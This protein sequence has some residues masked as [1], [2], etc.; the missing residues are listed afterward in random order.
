MPDS[1][2]LSA[3]EKRINADTAFHGF[4]KIDTKISAC[5]V[6]KCRLLQFAAP[7][8]FHEVHKMH[9]GEERDD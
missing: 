8:H 5:P 4:K 1:A 6:C 2:T 9:A 3:M 7:I